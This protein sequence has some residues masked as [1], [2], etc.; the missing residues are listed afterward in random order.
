MDEQHQQLKSAC[1]QLAKST[2]WDR[3][4]VDTDAIRTYADAIYNIA[5]DESQDIEGLGCTFSTVVKAVYYI[6]QAHAI[7]P[8][9]DDVQ[10]FRDTLRAVIE[11]ACP[12][13]SLDGEARNF[14][15]DM[16][17]GILS[18]VIEDE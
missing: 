14:L 4:P 12:N 13:S 17:R 18:F 15:A 7:P 9:K 10:W 6:D 11:V 1:Y 3:K 8:F 2:Y 5:L 16:G